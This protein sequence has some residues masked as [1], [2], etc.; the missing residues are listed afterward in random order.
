MKTILLFAFLHF[1]SSCIIA[2][3]VMPFSAQTN[4]CP[5]GVLLQ[6]MTFDPTIKTGVA[7]FETPIQVL[8]STVPM[9]IF[10][11]SV[12]A[13]PSVTTFYISASPQSGKPV[14]STTFTYNIS[15]GDQVSKSSFSLSGSPTQFTNPITVRPPIGSVTNASLP[16][17]QTFLIVAFVEA[18]MPS[19]GFNFDIQLIG[20]VQNAYW[21][22]SN[23]ASFQYSAMRWYNALL[24]APFDTSSS[25]RSTTW[26]E[27]KFDFSGGLSTAL[28]L[29]ICLAANGPQCGLSNSCLAQGLPT[30]ITLAKGTRS[31]TWN[32]LISSTNVGDTGCPP[33]GIAVQ[34]SLAQTSLPFFGFS[35]KASYSFGVRSLTP[36]TP[37]PTAAII[38]I[39]IGGVVVIAVV[40]GVIWYWWHSQKK[41]ADYQEL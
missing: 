31:Y 11:F 26:F 38:G 3:S 32:N 22:L 21:P 13:P 25:N 28:V 8:N 10:C 24:G 19:P 30:N 2:D 23:G 6:E 5:G 15:Y 16:S 17:T 29:E 39:V 18:F 40:I 4:M 1:F 34:L 41:K 14:P 36:T 35:F 27:F 37:F 7:L 20:T 9:G 33:N 12:T